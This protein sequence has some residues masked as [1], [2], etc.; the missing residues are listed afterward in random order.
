MRDLTCQEPSGN[1]ILSM[2]KRRI[3]LVIPSLQAGGMERV[4]SELAVYMASDDQNE[5][6]LVLYDSTRE[7]FYPV[8]GGVIIH[9]PDFTFKNRWKIVSTFRTI[10]FIRRTVTGI[11]P[12]ALL[13]FGELWNSFV[14]ISLFGLKVPVYISDRCSP[15]KRFNLIQTVLRCLLYPRSKGIIVQTALAKDIYAKQFRHRNIKVIGN[16]IRSI[17]P[18]GENR[19]NIVLSVGRFIKSKHHDRLIELFI[20]IELTGWKLVLIGYDH[21]GQS[22]LNLLQQIIDRRSANDRVLLLGKQTDVD[23]YYRQSK[24]FAFTSGSEGFPNVIGEAMSAGLPVI[25]FDCIAG[26]SEM[27]TNE[28]NGYLIPLYDYESFRQKL[29]TLMKDEEMRTRMGDKA[30]EDI[31]QFDINRVGSEYLNFILDSN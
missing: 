29:E 18:T 10:F 8:A 5:I 13:S 16:P 9:L 4:M 17:A 20:D 6:H 2:I 3:C 27:I 7:I 15:V 21:L 1:Q 22:N 12:I 19:E 25:A 30:R 31:K 28:I 14:M 24:I 11:S 26:P 23:H